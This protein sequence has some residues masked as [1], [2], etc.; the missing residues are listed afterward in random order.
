[1]DIE[2]RIASANEGGTRKSCI[3]QDPK[4]DI[5]LVRPL[6]EAFNPFEER[7]STV[8]EVGV[9]MIERRTR[10]IDKGRSAERMNDG[11]SEVWIEMTMGW[12]VQ[13]EMP[14]FAPLLTNS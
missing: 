12:P 6:R 10:R 8:E 11:M 13:S 5:Q 1:V 3:G 2:G 14:P 7:R 4:K 9:V